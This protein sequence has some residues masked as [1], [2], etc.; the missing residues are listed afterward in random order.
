MTL[1][2]THRTHFIMSPFEKA[3]L[4]SGLG[5]YLLFLGYRKGRATQLGQDTTLIDQ[6]IKE[7]TAKFE[8]ISKM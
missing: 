3:A 1:I 8:E 4:L 6:Q 2:M 7:A 5:A